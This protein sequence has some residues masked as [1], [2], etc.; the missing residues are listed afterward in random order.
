[1]PDPVT[2]G[3]ARRGAGA[4]LA[5]AG[6]ACVAALADA[7]WRGAEAWIAQAPFEVRPPPASPA[8][9]TTARFSV[10]LD[11]L[12]RAT[13]APLA[14]VRAPAVTPRG[15]REIP[16]EALDRAHREAPAPGLVL[17]DAAPQL[18]PASQRDLSALASTRAS[19]RLGDSGSSIEV[20]GPSVL[21]EAPV[22]V[23]GAVSDAARVI[24][25]LRAGFR[26]CYASSLNSDPSLGG[27]LRITFEVGPEGSVAGVRTAS[28][29]N[30]PPSLVACIAAQAR[31]ARFAPPAGSGAVLT[32]PVT[33]VPH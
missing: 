26:S 7:P 22:V 32:A 13:L 6:G 4:R 24:A 15:R 25:G 5:L 16:L 17:A 9:A 20:R 33:F 10:E 27:V 3:R 2:S 23:G 19:V 14:S 11:A 28:T 31:R 1:M 30:L 8:L 18:D 12:E 21:T 29:G